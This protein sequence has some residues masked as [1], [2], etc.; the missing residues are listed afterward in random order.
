MEHEEWLTKTTRGAS[1]NAAANRAKIV[2]RT[3][4]RQIERGK[5]D[6]ESVIKIAVA[7]SENPVHAL[8]DTDYLEA[9]YA[10]KVSP[11]VALRL[12]SEEALADEVLRRMKIGVSTNSPLTTPLDEITRSTDAPRVVPND[13]RVLPW[14]D[15][16]EY[17]ADSSPDEDR[18]REEEG[19]SPID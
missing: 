4:A 3:L 16:V 10:V 5:I 14:D 1:V 9:K 12:V 15:S 7:Y 18:L 8:V 2:Q 19:E 17:A 11:E 6:A 13:G